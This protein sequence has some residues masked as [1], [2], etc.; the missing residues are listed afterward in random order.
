L[1]VKKIRGISIMH[2]TVTPPF[3]ASSCC[4][5]DAMYKDLGLGGEI[6]I[7]NI[8]EDW[9]VDTSGGNIGHY[10]DVGKARPESV[11]LSFARCLIK[12]SINMRHGVAS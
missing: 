7:D 12:C 4:P 6:V 11:N 3:L 2:N 5:T 8:R 10:Q 1:Q 9:D